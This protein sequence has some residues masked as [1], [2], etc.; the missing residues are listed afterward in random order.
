MYM[1]DLFKTDLGG[2]K[3]LQLEAEL[4]GHT[5]E[6]LILEKLKNALNLPKDSKP[7]FA[8][9]GYKETDSP[10]NNVYPRHFTVNYEFELNGASESG[11]LNGIIKPVKT[12]D[13]ATG[14]ERD[15]ANCFSYLFSSIKDD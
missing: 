15:M 11:V 14:I 5:S 2:F 10:P 9:S 4:N 6:S 12:V 13:K 7:I 1:H 8:L 3:Q